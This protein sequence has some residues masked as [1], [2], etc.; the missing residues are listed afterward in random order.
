MNTYLNVLDFIDSSALAPLPVDRILIP[1]PSKLIHEII[2]IPYTDI[3]IITA[4]AFKL[5][6]DLIMQKDAV[7]SSKAAQ[8]LKQTADDFAT[9][10]SIPEHDWSKIRELEFQEKYREKMMLTRQLSM[11]RCTRC[12]NLN[13]HVRFSL[14]LSYRMAQF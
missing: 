1:D 5:D 2:L 4:Q 11:Y 13:D 10:H 14:K 9:L 7:A 12:P 8:M 6:A 3:A